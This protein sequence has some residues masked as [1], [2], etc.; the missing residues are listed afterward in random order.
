M[1]REQLA[2]AEAALAAIRRD[3]LPQNPRNYA[4]M[5]ESY[6]DVILSL[7]AEIDAYLGISAT[8]D[9]AEATYQEH[10]GVIRSI[11]LDSQSFI[12]RERG[13]SVPDLPCEYSAELEA[14]VKEHLD[15]RVL[16]SG[17]LEVSK[18]TQKARLSVDTIAL[19]TMPRE[20]SPHG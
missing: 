4:G 2:S 8:A 17:W 11:D 5:A 7:R 1:V 14:A 19:A 13:A 12:L 15:D 18:K 6:I 16:V 9:L 10:A 20:V 3:V